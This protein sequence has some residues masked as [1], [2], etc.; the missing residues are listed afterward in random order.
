[1]TTYTTLLKRA[2]ELR[3]NQ[4]ESERIIWQSLRKKRFKSLKFKRQQVIGNYIVDFICHSPKI[5]IECDGGQ[6]ASNI[7][8][9]LNSPYARK[10]C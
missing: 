2:K 4:T 8:Y 10:P 3:Q 5:I 7:P 9:D 1:M 6:H